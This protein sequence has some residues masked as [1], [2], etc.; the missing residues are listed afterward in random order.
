M[1]GNEPGDITRLLD[2]VGQ[3]D[4]AAA[5]DLLR[6]VEGCL[7]AKAAAMLQGQQDVVGVSDL[8][9]EGLIKVIS[10]LVQGKVKFEGRGRFF[11][12]MFMVM[13]Q[14]LVDHI[15]NRKA[16]KRDDARRRVPLDDLAE[17]VASKGESSDVDLERVNQCMA[18][19]QQDH[20]RAY[21]AV[22]LHYFEGMTI[23]DVAERLE[24]SQ[25]TVKN[26]LNYAL[27]FL[28]RCI[29]DNK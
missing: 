6:R 15:R 25:A 5:V 29:G 12:L 1:A 16:R 8:V 13:A 21:F 22:Y 24:C 7:R 19:L 3:G 28:R 2:L 11:A 23:V 4:E 14:L 10:L 20:E 9:Q 27:A 18:A 26:D 17:V